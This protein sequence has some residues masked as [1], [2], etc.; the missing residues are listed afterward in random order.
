MSSTVLTTDRSGT[1]FAR[2]PNE[3]LARSLRVI[4]NELRLEHDHDG[5]ACL[6]HGEW[7]AGLFR[8][9]ESYLDHLS[10]PPEETTPNLL[11][12]AVELLAYNDRIVSEVRD[13]VL[14]PLN[15]TSRRRSRGSVRRDFLGYHHKLR[16]CARRL[17]D[18]WIG[19]GAR[20]E[21]LSNYFRELERGSAWRRDVV[22]VPRRLFEACLA[23]LHDEIGRCADEAGLRELCRISRRVR[24]VAERL[25]N[26]NAHEGWLLDRARRLLRSALE[27]EIPAPSKPARAQTMRRYRSNIER[28]LEV[29]ERMDA[30]AVR[31]RPSEADAVRPRP[32]E[33]DAVRPRPSEADAGRREPDR[34]AT[35]S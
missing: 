9:Y 34:T 29:L 31:P 32:S 2:S 1:L 19:V 35:Q 11:S 17:D 30:G 18:A 16:D 4:G 6:E 24:Y 12:V 14:D 5:A 15:Q 7:G 22:S 26:C 13:G 10:S 33:A 28:R 20:T 23:A 25:Q 3:A 27:V 21:Q 8:D